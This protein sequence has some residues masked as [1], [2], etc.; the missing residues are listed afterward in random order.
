MKKK[1]SKLTKLI[2]FNLVGLLFIFMIFSAN[3]DSFNEKMVTSISIII[4]V[5]ICFCFS[6]V[7]ESQL[8][9]MKS[10]DYSRVSK[11]IGIFIFI[12]AVLRAC[13]EITK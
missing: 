1:I 6:V 7:V 11:L 2:F 9:K 13:A 5:N 10:A 3:Q 12:I 4:V 8:D